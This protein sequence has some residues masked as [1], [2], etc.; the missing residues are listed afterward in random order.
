MI[1]IVSFFALFTAAQAGISLSL[2]RVRQAR[3]FHILIFRVFRA[4]RGWS[5]SCNGMRTTE[6]T[7]Y[8]ESGI[9]SQIDRFLFYV[10]RVFRGSNSP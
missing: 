8:T 6:I 1:P 9:K 5:F 10:V 3:Q 2:R 4:F 7:E